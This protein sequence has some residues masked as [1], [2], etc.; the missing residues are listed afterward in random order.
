MFRGP[1]YI[2][3]AF[4]TRTQQ[5]TSEHIQTIH[6]REN[7]LLRFKQIYK[8]LKQWLSILMEFC[9]NPCLGKGH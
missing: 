2:A 8:G 1:S 6:M 3:Y 7:I 4:E 5:N 9:K